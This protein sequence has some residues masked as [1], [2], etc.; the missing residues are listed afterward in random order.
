MNGPIDTD[1]EGWKW[2]DSKQNAIIFGT[3]DDD[4][5]DYASSTYT[6][7]VL[8]REEMKLSN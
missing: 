2:K 4:S 3:E 5:G 6:I 1:V 8:T 7:D